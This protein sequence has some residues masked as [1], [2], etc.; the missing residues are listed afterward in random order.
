MEGFQ[1]I[2]F[3]GGGCRCFWQAG[4]WSEAAPALGVPD[5]GVAG[6]SAGAAFACAAFA[7]VIERVLEEFVA[8]VAAN[9]R[10]V[11]PGNAL[12]G[13]PVFP[14]ERIYQETILATLDAEA[15][16][17]LH[18]GP[19]VRV[20]VGRPPAW[21]GPSTGVALGAAAFLAE[22]T[23]RNV[24]ASWGKRLGFRAEFASVRSCRTPEEL[25]ELILHSSCTPPLTGLYRRSG[26]PVLDGGVYDN[27]PVDAGTPA[28]RVLVL[29][30]R[31]HPEACL[32]RVPGRV[33]LQPSEPVPISRW[34]YTSPERVHATYELGR[35]DG[36]RFV[37]E[38][39][40]LVAA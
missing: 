5:Q 4:F 6:V 27:A 26:A 21:A 10:N 36:E 14:H 31:R 18:A 25:A 39:L 37:R 33:Y 22:Q 12:R 15:L 24:H 32:P 35:A 20:L 23:A 11:Y 7:G 40:D 19:E 2:V 17:R 9:E 13:G 30:S 28:E 16:A 8:R 34:D 1:S 3:A 29:L 38:G